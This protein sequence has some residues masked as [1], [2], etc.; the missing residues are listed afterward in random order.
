MPQIGKLLE[1][2]LY[3]LLRK[4]SQESKCGY[5]FNIK[6]PKLLMVNQK[7]VWNIPFPVVDVGKHFIFS[8][9]VRFSLEWV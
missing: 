3:I 5:V 4:C 2:P 8:E 1:S 9:I 6:N 7:T